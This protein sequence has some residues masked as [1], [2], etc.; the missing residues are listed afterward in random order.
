M[1]AANA[2]PGALL[3]GRQTLA[4]LRRLDLTEGVA[5]DVDDYVAQAVRLADDSAAR[6]RFARELRERR[7]LL[8]GDRQVDRALAQFL[9]TVEHPACG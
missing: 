2:V 4:M 9:A 1:V 7:G 6:Q 8:F 5:R 3:R